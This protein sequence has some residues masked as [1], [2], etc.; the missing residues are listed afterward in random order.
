VLQVKALEY[1][2]QSHLEISSAGVDAEVFTWV[3]P[4]SAPVAGLSQEHKKPAVNSA[5]VRSLILAIE[6]DLMSPDAP[7]FVGAV[8]NRTRKNRRAWNVIGSKT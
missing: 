5:R 6:L 2:I 4:E 7:T 8:K 1:V 3:A